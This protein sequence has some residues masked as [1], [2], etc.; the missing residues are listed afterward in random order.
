MDRRGRGIGRRPRRGG[1]RDAMVGDGHAVCVSPKV[2]HDVLGP[3]ER[4]PT[5]DVPLF[6]VER[7]QKRVER[8]RRIDFEIPLVDG[9]LEEGEKLSPKESAQ[10]IDVDKEGVAGGNPGLPIK[11]QP[12]TC[13]NAVD[14]GMVGQQL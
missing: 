8:C 6:G 5:V 2:F 11:G 4:L 9:T 10:D 3:G 12:A 7:S 14:V 1:S 13:H